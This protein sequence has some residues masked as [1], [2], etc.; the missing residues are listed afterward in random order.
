V[1][2][3]DGRP[4]APLEL[5]AD[6]AA[7]ARGLLGRD[8]LAGALWLPRTRSVHTVGMRFALDVAACD[9]DGRVV[10]V[11]TLVPGRLLLPRLGVRSV[12]EAQA[13]AFERWGLEEG[14]HLDV[15]PRRPD[16]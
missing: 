4:V 6:R 15:A 5:A 16:G 7:R 8:A 1:L 12:L 2:A 14:A 13:G 10:H 3:V 9:A 11:A